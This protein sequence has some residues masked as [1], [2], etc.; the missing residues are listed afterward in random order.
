M[1]FPDSKPLPRGLGDKLIKIG[2]SG[3]EYEETY[4]YATIAIPS[5]FAVAI[6]YNQYSDLQ[7]GWKAES[8]HTF[9]R[10]FFVGHDA[11]FDFSCRNGVNLDADYHRVHA[12]VE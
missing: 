11:N 7:L 8:N 1:Y 9:L 3:T 6:T 10:F 5:S 12:L 4:E 2:R